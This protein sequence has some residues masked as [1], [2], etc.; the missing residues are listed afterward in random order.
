MRELYWEAHRRTDLVRYGYFTGGE[1]NWQWKGNDVNGA[2][3]NEIF[4]IYP[5]PFADITANQ[6]LDQNPGY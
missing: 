5:L 4:D 1:Y 6:N 3:T 2:A